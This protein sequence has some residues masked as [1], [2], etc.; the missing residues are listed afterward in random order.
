M[1]AIH[2]FWD[3]DIHKVCLVISWMFYFSELGL[4][5]NFFWWCLLEDNTLNSLLTAVSSVEYCIVWI[6]LSSS[7]VWLQLLAWMV[8]SFE[9]VVQAGCKVYSQVNTRFAYRILRQA[10]ISPVGIVNVAHLTLVY[11][12]HSINIQRHINPFFWWFTQFMLILT[13]VILC[14]NCSAKTSGYSFLIVSDKRLLV[15]E[16]LIMGVI[17]H[18]F[19]WKILNQHLNNLYLFL[20]LLNLCIISFIRILHFLNFHCTHFLHLFVFGHIWV[21]RHIFLFLRQINSVNSQPIKNV[22]NCL[23]KLYLGYW[24]SSFLRNFPWRNSLS[25]C[26]RSC[27]WT[28]YFVVF[29][30]LRFIYYIFIMVKICWVQIRT[31][32]ITKS[33]PKCFCWSHLF[34][35]YFLHSFFKV[36]KLLFKRFLKLILL[37][38]SILEVRLGAIFRKFLE[39]F[40]VA[41]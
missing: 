41:G 38:K 12:L 35:N 27:N 9:A 40:G 39:C 32:G 7:S 6:V 24:W 5:G 4:L 20:Q 28:W 19:P 10:I 36:C 37:C 16:W 14:S 13:E 15:T 26:R 22:I 1:E 34:F 33:L 25:S 23:W 21:K 3:R 29:F 17:F 8:V 11:L 30:H 18:L 2:P 31:L